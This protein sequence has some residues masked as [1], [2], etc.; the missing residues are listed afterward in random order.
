MRGAGALAGEVRGVSGV[1]VED[2]GFPEDLGAHMVPEG[3][4]ALVT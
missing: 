4:V 3:R 1:A 2:V